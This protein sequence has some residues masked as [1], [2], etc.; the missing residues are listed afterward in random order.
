[1]WSQWFRSALGPA[2]SLP[3]Q[4]RS[5]QQSSSPRRLSQHQGQRPRNLRR[6]HLMRNW[7]WKA[8]RPSKESTNRTTLSLPPCPKSEPYFPVSV[9][10]LRLA[11]TRNLRTRTPT[12]R[13]SSLRNST[14]ENPRNPNQAKLTPS[15]S[16][17][18]NPVKSRLG[19]GNRSSSRAGRQR[20]PWLGQLLQ[21]WKVMIM[22]IGR[23]WASCR[24]S[25]KDNCKVTRIRTGTW[26]RKASE[27]VPTFLPIPSNTLK[28]NPCSFVTFL[29]LQENK[30]SNLA[31]KMEKQFAD[32]GGK[33]PVGGVSILPERKDEVQDLTVRLLLWFYTCV[34]L[35]RND[36][37]WNSLVLW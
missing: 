19:L 3:E 14:A 28:F 31:K 34:G 24:R 27:K 5:N 15:T 25:T 18:A 7:R 37:T 17:P 33:K 10:R 2:A 1:M 8:S 30:I 36:L 13:R 9:E 4:L 29:S 26:R 35:L 20:L 16:N 6:Q 21:R 22:M 32:R 11:P 23:R 12:W